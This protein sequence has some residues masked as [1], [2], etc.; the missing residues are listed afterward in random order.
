[1]RTLS[2]SIG[3][4]GSFERVSVLYSVRTGTGRRISQNACARAGRVVVIRGF[5]GTKT[6][7]PAR[8]LANN[9]PA[10]AEYRFHG[11]LYRAA[12]ACGQAGVMAGWRISCPF[13]LPSQAVTKETGMR[14]DIVRYVRRS[15]G[16]RGTGDF[17]SSPQ[18]DPKF[19][20]NLAE[21]SGKCMG[22]GGSNRESRT[23]LPDEPNFRRVKCRLQ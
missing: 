4:K 19:E 9:A 7:G 3:A 11:L 13:D 10:N 23:G 22:H 15:G 18:S 21:G 14:R 20:Q 5:W 2:G 16:D 6:A 12:R 17:G 1:M 8:A